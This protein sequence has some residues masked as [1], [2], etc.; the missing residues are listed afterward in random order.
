[1]KVFL[2]LMLWLATIG[3]P[4]LAVASDHADPMSLDSF[5]PQDRPL[6][7]ITDLH[8]FLVDRDGAPILKAEDLSR[9]H[10]LIVSLC[11]RRRLLYWQIDDPKLEQG[12]HEL[13]FRVHLDLDSEVTHYD[14]NK[15]PDGRDYA[16][17]LKELDELI[18]KTQTE[19]DAALASQQKA[20]DPA[21]A[22]ALMEL[23]S[24]LASARMERAR[25]IDK[26]QYDSRMEA[27]Y[28][29]VVV[30]PH[31]IAEEAL[32]DFRLKLVKEDKITSVQL[33]K[34]VING[35]TGRTNQIAGNRVRVKDLSAAPDSAP[36]GAWRADAI[37]VQ[38]G[39][40]DDP[41]V[42]PR[43]FRGNV[44]G[45]VASIPLTQLRLPDGGPADH[46]TILLW[47]TTHADDGKQVDHVGRSLRTQLPR[48]GH[49]NELHPSQHVASILRRHSHPTLLENSLSTFIAPLEAHRFYDA[50]PDVMIYD[51][52]R[53]AVFPNGRWLE[54]DVAK[55]LADAGETLLYE[56]SLLESR[57]F[58]RAT[59]NDKPFKTTFPYLADPWTQQE[60]LAHS[61]PSTRMGDFMVPNAQDAG[62]TALPDFSPDVWKSIWWS[63]V[64]ALVVMGVLS[65]LLL[66]SLGVRLFVAAVTLISLYALMPVRAPALKPMMPGFMS[67]P[68][69][70]LGRTLWGAGVATL[71]G[72]VAVHSAGVRRGV[73][74][75]AKAWPHGARLDQVGETTDDLQYAGSTF[76]QVRKSVFENP[77]NSPSAWGTKGTALPVYRVPLSTLAKGLFLGTKRYPFRKASQRTIDSHA[78]LRPGEDG[79]GFPRLLHAHGVCLIGTW[80]ITQ[81]TDYTGYFAT[82]K[83][84]LIVAR[85]SSEGRLR[86]EPRSLSLVGKL[87]P[88]CD[89]NEK[90]RTASFFTLSALGGVRSESIFDAILRNAPDVRPLSSAR[91]FVRL[92]LSL[93]AF[94]GVDTH[95]SERQLYEIAEAGEDTSSAAWK[96]RC[97]NYMQ[98]TIKSEAVTSDSSTDD[99]RDDVLTQIYD[100]GEF[101][102]LRKLVFKIEVSDTGAVE[103][104]I[105]KSLAG[106]T[107]N[108]IGEIEL[109]EAVASYNGDFVIH[110]HHP[111]WR[112]DRNKPQ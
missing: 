5:L 70:R 58:P 74:S 92:I 8:A 55:T 13:S 52:R 67:Q 31:A 34:V 40:F 89:G 10:Q 64:I 83:Q 23:E 16:Q 19:R 42:F 86:R 54:D 30:A 93:L 108:E 94:R 49:L 72:L 112:G 9:A 68:Q 21:V 109:T 71:L 95:P 39:I 66:R 111:R 65:F 35:I 91:G 62:A 14:A 105:N 11:V 81:A 96:T 85:Y 73:A 53:P 90:V 87:F 77:Y 15:L 12:L 84:C 60:T 79:R 28:G 6:A 76:E 56:L 29:G 82:D 18:A 97:P 36:A 98:L 103:G 51:L 61:A 47:A 17:T 99:F 50:A 43:F 7:N 33:D 44:I 80:R 101:E 22:A 100:R 59:T 3:S 104:W 107:W 2:R 102:A 32:L 75:A 46:R 38:T 78:D 88:T 20:P 37:N 57:Q 63:L 106:A 24:A 4:A 69:E 26:R 41:F 110:F 45:V 1:M 48:F 25:M 27:L